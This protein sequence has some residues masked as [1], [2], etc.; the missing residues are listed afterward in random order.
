MGLAI[1]CEFDLRCNL[2]CSFCYNHWRAVSPAAPRPP[3][4]VATSRALQTLLESIDVEQIALSGGEITLHPGLLEF[5]DLI[6]KFDVPILLVTNGTT[7]NGENL[8]SLVAAGVNSFQ[9]SL[10]G[11]QPEAHDRIAGVKSW[12][13]VIRA[14]YNIAEQD[15][16]CSVVFVATNQNMHEFKSVVEICAV[17]GIKDIVFNRF[18]GNAGAGKVNADG[19]VVIDHGQLVDALAAGN[20]VAAANDITIHLGT[21]LNLERVDRNRLQAVAISDCSDLSNRK[22]TMDASG[23]LRRCP[24][25]SI[26]LGSVF[27][28]NLKGKTRQ[29]LHDISASKPPLGPGE[30]YCSFE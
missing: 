5:V 10:L 21:P 2:N 3:E 18:V 9:V 23:N 1:W 14:L 22:L 24:Q 17:M 30:C 16:S 20:D 8:E 19:L 26:T 29:W 27:D 25:S 4:T 12:D 11:G 7:L 15:I 13:K 28:K 6:K